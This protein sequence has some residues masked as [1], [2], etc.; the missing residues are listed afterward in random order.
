MSFKRNK[1]NFKINPISNTVEKPKIFFC[2]RQ[3]H[4]IGEIFPVATPR[5]KVN[6]NGADEVSFTVTK[7]IKNYNDKDINVLKKKYG[8]EI[9]NGIATQYEN[10][11][12][13]SVV[14]VQ[15]FG[16]FEV[17]P[18]INDYS[19]MVK[20]LSGNSLGETELGQLHCTLE[21]NTDNDIAMPD[22][23]QRVIYSP[24]N[25]DAS[26]IHKILSYAPTYEVGE[27]DET[28]AGLQRT[29]SFNN[30][31]IISCFSKISE[32]VNCIFDV[33]VRRND[34][35][36]IQ[37]IVNI[38]DAQYCKKC[39]KRHII[40]GVC[41][42]CK[43][44]DIGGIGE[45]TTILISTESLSDEI[46]LTPDGNLKNCLI[47]DG[48]DEIITDTVKGL[49]PSGTNKIYMFSDETK[50]HWSDNLKSKYN[51]YVKTVS[52]N[53]EEYQNTLELE[54]DIN[55][56]ILYLQSGRMPD[57]E[58]ADRDLHEET[59]H[60]ISKFKENFSDGI[61]IIEDSES[62]TAKNSTVRQ[63]FALF[64]DKGYAV[65][66]NEGTVDDNN[67]WT[68]QLIIY[69]IQNNEVSATIEVGTNGSTISYSDDSTTVSDGLTI[70]FSKNNYENYIKRKVALE[71]ENYE[72]I[73]SEGYNTP[74]DWEKYSLNRLYSYFS[75]YDECIQ[76]LRDLQ[77]T[78]SLSGIKSKAEEFISEYNQRK[79]EISSYMKR[80][81]N[82]IYYLYTYYGV[83]ESSYSTSLPSSQDI[84]YAEYGNNPNNLLYNNA[85]KAFIDMEHYIR[86]GTIYGG[87]EEEITDHP[88]YCSYCNSTNVTLNGCNQCQKTDYIVTYGA[89]AEKIKQAYNNNT[90]SLE[91]Q[92]R[93]IRNKCN[94]YDFLVVIDDDGNVTDNSLYKEFYSYI[95]ED[96]YENS[97]FIS[98]GLTSGNNTA[99]INNTKELIQKA[100]QEL[101]KVCVSQ[102][103]L[104]GNVHS[105]VAYSELNKDDF[106]IQN[107]YDKFVL[108]NFM[109]YICD[110]KTY[111][112]RLSSEEFSWNDEGCELNVEF[113]DVVRFLGGGIS[114]IVSLVQ[115]VNQIA[116]TA[117]LAK[118]QAEK[119]V[120]TNKE[121]QKIKEEG[122]Q[123]TLANVLSARNI[124]VQINE[125]GIL[126]RKYDYDLDDY[127]DY[128][129][130]LINRNLVMTKDN[131]KH[132]DMAVGL[133]YYGNELKYGVWADVLVGDLI[134]GNKLK[135]YGGGDGTKDN[136]TV[137]IDGN[138][139]TLD[140]GAVTWI[141]PISSDDAIDSNAVVGLDDF[142][143]SVQDSL[144]VTKITSDSVISPKIGAQYL[145][146]QNN[147]YSIEIDPNHSAGEKTLENYLFCI[148][149]KTDDSRIISVDTNGN[150]YFKGD[151]YATGGEF[152]GSINCGEN[153]SV[154]KNGTLISKSG[155]VGGCKIGQNSL[156][157]DTTDNI[158]I[159]KTG[160]LFNFNDKNG[161]VINK[162][163]KK[164]QN[165]LELVN[166]S[167]ISSD[168]ILFSA[169][170]TY[171]PVTLNMNEMSGFDVNSNKIKLT[172]EYLELYGNVTIN[173][174]KMFEHISI[175]W[176]SNFYSS[177]RGISTFA[178]GRF[179]FIQGII[180]PSLVGT[181]LIAATIDDSKY[182][183]SN[184]TAIVAS[185]Y[186]YTAEGEITT[187]GIIKFNIK[188]IQDIRFIAFWISKQV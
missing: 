111:K 116:T 2:D 183:P 95:R 169:G 40:N 184:N 113:T 81:E 151:I 12:D 139:I 150:G 120:E 67:N 42:D 79:S 68:G 75:G 90:I 53:E 87:S 97:N 31:D 82:F 64:A 41:D 129:M 78:T 74:K 180:K 30:E 181:E 114:D 73:E 56:L 76:T 80:L 60:V 145:Y 16:Y 21:C 57:I 118:T 178:I 71:T 141:N 161:L 138:G 186:D 26:L 27:V 3:L 128:Q 11:I 13:Y 130:K 188:G 14:F 102:H 91:E 6:L 136:A 162:F 29:F 72:Y 173:G 119:G 157:I 165:T 109:R 22:Y 175:T 112:L 179:C 160:I 107:A 148:R 33:V 182:Y 133:G 122:L 20:T 84:N 70:K 37:R 69:Q 167:Y 135:I 106:P 158:E 171:N 50:S 44:T 48:G 32:E 65:K 36:E 156:T 45:D 47:V 100:K 61:G 154:D 54:Y 187:E 132:A 24:T 99:L 124:D 94:L 126:L 153:F 34:D 185:S 159:G 63:T 142:K 144:G 108:G 172:S 59:E 5:V 166:S 143:K 131:W 89:L 103:T 168:G 49:L 17:S 104:S 43:S 155:F 123:S 121:F 146:V 58:T 35:G 7:N 170:D 38:Y 92:R 88:L 176:N 55:D 174:I 115:S 25:K 137:T 98:D 66:Y 85:S 93:Q 110:G 152:T 51:E 62:T 140:G 147:N 177:M 19:N 46:T 15:G 101:A 28:I 23:I 8:I 18:T 164:S 39:G 134:A 96:I 163:L 83:Y 9:E 86:Y 52:E 117:N 1:Y 10:L 4:K 77:N 125:K 127:S 105:F 149:K